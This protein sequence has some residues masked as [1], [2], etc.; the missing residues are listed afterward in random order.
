MK[1]KQVSKLFTYK[2]PNI[3]IVGGQKIRRKFPDI[4]DHYNLELRFTQNP[5]LEKVLDS[6]TICI[7]VDEEMIKL[8]TK[9]E[10]TRLLKSTPHLPIFYIARSFR[11]PQFYKDL[12]EKGL[13][14]VL[15]WPADSKIFHDL[16]IESLKPQKGFKGKSKGDEKL[17]KQ[18]K[19][20]LILNL[21]KPK[22]DVYVIK[23]NVFLVGK[24]KSLY[25]KEMIRSESIKVLGVRNVLTEHLLVKKRTDITDREL[26]RKLKMYIGNVAKRGKKALSVKVKDKVV[27]LIGSATSLSHLLSIEEFAMKQPGVVKVKRQISLSPTESRQN[28]KKAKALEKKIKNIFSGVKYISVRIFGHYVEVSGTVKFKEDKNLVEKFVLQSLPVTRVINKLYVAA[29]NA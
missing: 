9:K 1:S 22:V 19:A 16:I 23:G 28:T 21:E 12:Y 15:N 26:E 11:S 13:Q 27:T 5:Q 24:V 14:G 8:T 17:A 6:Q 2:K 7:I 29:K 18:V 10:L 4:E 3:V 25:E 20:H